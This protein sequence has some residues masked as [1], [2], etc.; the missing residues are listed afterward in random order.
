VQRVLDRNASAHVTVFF[1]SKVRTDDF[2][3]GAREGKLSRQERLELLA[4]DPGLLRTLASEDTRR[5]KLVLTI[6]GDHF[7]IDRDGQ[8]FDAPV[9]RVALS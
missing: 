7:Y 2:V 3:A 1:D 9:T 6:V 5:G 4:I 8:T